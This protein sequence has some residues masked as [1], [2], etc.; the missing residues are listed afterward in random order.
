MQPLLDVRNLTVEVPAGRGKPP[1]RIIDNISYTLED[2]QTLGIVGESGSGK[3]MQALAMLG[4]SQQRGR[5][6]AGGE[7][8][9]KGQNLLALSDKALR[10]V[11]GVQIGMIFQEPM[12]S[13]NPVLTIGRQLAEPLVHHMGMSHAKARRRAIDLLSLVGITDPAQRVGQYPFQFSG[14]MRQRVMIAMALACKPRL[15]IGDEPTT[16][17]DVTVQAQIIELIR[18]LR[19]EMKMSI[20]WITHDMGVVAALADRVQVLYAGKIMEMGPV[21][22]VFRQPR[23]AYTWA[24]LQ[25]IPKRGQRPREPLFQ[26]AGQPVDPARRPPGDPFAPR[27][28]FATERCHREA[29]PLRAVS[30]DTPLHRAA[31]WYDLPRC[32][33]DL[34]AGEEK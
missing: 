3:S 16:A 23:S 33:A 34:N 19:D 7:V 32:L 4:L 6:R 27:N 31:A 15:L 9:F 28:P 21:D 25:S 8:L 10:A 2:N 17:L 11:R 24:L 1:V 22:Q 30:P 29:P 14:G 5:A 26:I 20:I 18:E 13:L 12:T